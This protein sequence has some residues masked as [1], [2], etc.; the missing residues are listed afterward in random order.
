MVYTTYHTM[1]R[2]EVRNKVRTSGLYKYI[3]YPIIIS[4]ALKPIRLTI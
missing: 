2:L 1:S 3:F 4:I